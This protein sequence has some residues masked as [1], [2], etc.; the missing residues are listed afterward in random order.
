M[1]MDVMVKSS[2]LF[3]PNYLQYHD[4]KAIDVRLH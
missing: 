2:I 3:T 1:I 4:S